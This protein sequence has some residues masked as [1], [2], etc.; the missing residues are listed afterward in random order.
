MPYSATYA[1]VY[2]REYGGERH[3]EVSSIGIGWGDTLGQPTATR[4]LNI[5]FKIIARNGIPFHFPEREE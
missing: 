2:E 3:L 4:K 5:P 1:R